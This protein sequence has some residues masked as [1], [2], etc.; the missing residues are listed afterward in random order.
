MRPSQFARVGGGWANG[1]GRIWL[2]G[3]FGCAWLMGPIRMCLA[4]GPSLDVSGLW[5]QLI[6]QSSS[7]K[8]T[9]CRYKKATWG[10]PPSIARVV[11]QC[12]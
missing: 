12:S 11:E 1:H 10:V 7:C 9:A 5:A 3:P 2:W 6:K 8:A 4:D